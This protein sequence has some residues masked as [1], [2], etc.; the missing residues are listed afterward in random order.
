M[1]KL[2]PGQPSIWL[3][4]NSLQVGLDANAVIVDELSPA[5]QRFIRYLQAGIAD[6]QLHEAA[7]TA[8]LP[9]AEAESL[10]R[11]LESQ[12]LQ[13]APIPNLGNSQKAAL[14]LLRQS[15]PDFAE[16][17]RLSLSS[18]LDGIG[19]LVSRAANIIHLETLDRTGAT[20]LR[21]L[22]NSGIAQFWTNERG[23]VTD[24]DVRGLGYS[25]DWLGRSRFDAAAALA[26][27]FSN[28][29]ALLNAAKHR[30]RM[31][32]RVD[33]AILCGGA[34]VDPERYER[35]Q[36]LGVPHLAICYSSLGTRVS[37]IMV[38]NKNACLECHERQLG[39]TDPLQ[40]VKVVQLRRNRTPYDDSSSV[41]FA[42]AMTVASVGEFVDSNHGFAHTA[43]ERSGWE[44]ERATGLISRLEWPA[45]PPCSCH[46]RTARNL[47]GEEGRPNAST[48]A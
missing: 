24:E 45:M 21:G 6:Q 30:P 4:P 33:L 1:F 9:L 25:K 19:P 44:F 3:S 8:R 5:H 11:R 26:D 48:A 23:P 18:G 16:L 14:T 35:W 38:P 12:L 15:N 28:R 37:P 41:L 43:F 40:A 7:R 22:A 46:Q 29:V 31:L 2:N 13:S 10:L 32:D 17:V 20:L 27:G 36:Q 34:S 42:A 47:D 39:A